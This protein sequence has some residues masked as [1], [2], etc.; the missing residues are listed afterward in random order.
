MVLDL[1]LEGAKSVATP[2]VKTAREAIECD[3]DLP[4][5]KL[6]AFR[7][8][9]ARANY[10]AADRPEIQFSSKEICRWMA[11]PTEHGV[12]ALK[13]LGRF[14]EG[15]RRVIFS[16]PFQSADKIDT[17]SDTDWA[18]CLRTRKSTS[19]GCLML[20]AGISSK[21]GAVLKDQSP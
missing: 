15:H 21:A 8:V 19:G 16:Y 1:G 12:A 9:V 13:R 10:L 7:G 4:D 3:T 2:G 6:T 18:G 11:S 5:H 14:L 20:E 17:Y